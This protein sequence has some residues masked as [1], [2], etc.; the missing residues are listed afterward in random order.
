MRDT[1]KVL[2]TWHPLMIGVEKN[3]LLM[4]CVTRMD[5]GHRENNTKYDIWKFSWTNTWDQES[6]GIKSLS[7]PTIS[8]LSIKILF[9]TWPRQ[10]R[11]PSMK[12]RWNL[13][14]RFDSLTYFIKSVFL[15]GIFRFIVRSVPSISCRSHSHSHSIRLVAWNQKDEKLWSPNNY[16]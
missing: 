3:V 11:H 10:L 13:L 7:I 8:S 2:E 6:F 4:K 12:N 1:S 9:E 16:F 5:L 14:L 15:F